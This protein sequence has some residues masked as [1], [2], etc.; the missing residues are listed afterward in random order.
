LQQVPPIKQL[1]MLGKQEII[2]EHHQHQTALEPLQMFLNCL[3]LVFM[4]TQIQL[5]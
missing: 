5:V 4:Q 2:L 3:M 1:L